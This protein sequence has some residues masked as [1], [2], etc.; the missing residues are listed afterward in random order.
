MTVT[1]GIAPERVVLVRLR[2]NAGCPVCHG[3]LVVVDDGTVGDRAVPFVACTECEYC[4]E[5]PK[6][7]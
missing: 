6:E 7:G 2:R 5:L 1:K 4:L 3:H